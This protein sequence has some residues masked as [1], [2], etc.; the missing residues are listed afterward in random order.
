M[1][2]VAL[3]QESGVEAGE[4][5]GTDL[6]WVGSARRQAA[7]KGCVLGSFLSVSW[8]SIL[9]SG[10]EDDLTQGKKDQPP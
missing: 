7:G 3:S 10:H 9:G 2:P 8:V 1:S 5:L 6:A 4:A